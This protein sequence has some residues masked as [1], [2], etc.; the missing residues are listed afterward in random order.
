M[1]VAFQTEG[2]AIPSGKGS[3]TFDASVTFDTPVNSAEAA[4]KG[5][6]LDFSSSDHHINV[7]KATTRVVSISG[8]TVNI[9][10][11]CQ[12]ADKNYDD[13]YWGFVS[14]LVIADVQ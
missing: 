5:F 3:R 10:I 13:E 14:T 4:L 7:V 6:M 12:Y 9:Q 2:V 8:R 11:G 1:P